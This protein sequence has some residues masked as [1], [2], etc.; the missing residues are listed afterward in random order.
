VFFYLGHIL[1]RSDQPALLQEVADK[2]IALEKDQGQFS[3]LKLA[4]R[5]NTVNKLGCTYLGIVD[6]DSISNLGIVDLDAEHFPRDQCLSSWSRGEGGSVLQFLHKDSAVA[7]A[8]A[9][10]ACKL[11]QQVAAAEVEDFVSN[12]EHSAILEDWGF[13]IFG[14]FP[15][16]RYYMCAASQ[17]HLRDSKLAVQ[18]AKAQIP[19]LLNPLK[20]AYAHTQLACI[21]LPARSEYVTDAPPSPHVSAPRRI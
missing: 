12:T 20:Q 14:M 19:H 7:M 21:L 18:Y 11:P 4:A 16:L 8:K 3:Q 6:L 13:H 10:M 9:L 15:S 17:L 1:L 5:F 2:L